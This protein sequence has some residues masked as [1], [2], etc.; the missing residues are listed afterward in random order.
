MAKG[1][2]G[3]VLVTLIVL[4]AAVKGLTYIT[5]GQIKSADP[6]GSFGSL[7]SGFLGI[8]DLMFYGLV[9]L[10]IILIPYYISKRNK[11]KTSQP[12]PANH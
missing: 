10:I 12:K 4:A 7:I 9:A 11:S 8:A 5:G 3:N 1:K 2:S 6:T